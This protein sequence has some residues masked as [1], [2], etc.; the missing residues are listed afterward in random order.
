MLEQTGNEDPSVVFQSEHD[1]EVEALIQ[2]MNTAINEDQRHVL[3]L[4]FVEG[5]NVEET[6]RITGKSIANVKVI[7]SRGV[8]KLRQALNRR[9]NESS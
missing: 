4:R 8:D 9:F 3:V 1:A 6:A 2:A 5:F 7:Q